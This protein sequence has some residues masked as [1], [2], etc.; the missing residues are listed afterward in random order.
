MDSEIKTNFPDGVN[1]EGYSFLDVF[2]HPEMVYGAYDFESTRKMVKHKQIEDDSLPKT[3]NV[4]LSFSGGIQV[5]FTTNSPEIF[6]EFTCVNRKFGNYPHV[7]LS[8]QAG[9]ACLFRKSGEHTWLNYSLNIVG[10]EMFKVTKRGFLD[11]TDSYDVMLVL[12]ILAQVEE[13]KI[14]YNKSSEILTN[15]K[16]PKATVGFLGSNFTFGIGVTTTALMFSNIIARKFDIEAYNFA[17]EDW[18]WV[19]SGIDNVISNM[20]F[21]AL[22][23]ECDNPIQD[24]NLFYQHFFNMLE[25]LC[26]E[27][28][29][30]SLILFS[31]PYLSSEMNCYTERRNHV[32][33]SVCKL[34]SMGYHKIFFID[35]YDIFNHIEKEYCSY[36]NKFYNDY[37]N[38]VMYKKIRRVIIDNSQSFEWAGGGK[39]GIFE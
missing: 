34:N 17:V 21:D 35:G 12:P 27:H 32:L 18:N 4:G 1:Q 28:R 13:L 30:T 3:T 26:R 5:I 11:N 24:N 38:T 16:I 7:G 6:V 19:C 2:Q 39:N 8:A 29:D 33:Q 23:I 9:I 31:Q 15:R 22:V 10:K 14:W 37:A 20:N 36:S 25:Q